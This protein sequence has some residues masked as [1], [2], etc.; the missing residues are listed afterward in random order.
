MTQEEQANKGERIAKFLSRAGI[1][2]RR[3]AERLIQD[4]VVSVN[5]AILDT[6]AFFVTD[7]DIIKVN[8]KTVSGKDKTRLWAYY[9][10]RGCLTSDSDPEERT[11]V[12]DLLPRGLPR[13]MAVGRLDYNSEGLLLLTNDG[14]FKRFLELPNVNIQ[15]RYRAR[16]F[17]R[18]TQE[19]LD[20]L[21]EGV[22]VD[23]M[24]YA[25]VYAE[26][27]KIQGQNAWVTFTLTEGKNRE[28]RKLMTY[29]G[30]DVNR[31]IR[32]DYGACSLGK[33]TDGDVKEIPEEY[34]LKKYSEYF[35]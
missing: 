26:L 29:L 7:S 13:L 22:V 2:S 25:P 32:T 33:M 31:L 35:N 3:E 16:A 14:G 19:R 17:G 20:V 1:A 18:I 6:P 10:P 30:Y 12:F 8:D 4:G 24:H 23:G 28:I 15:R 21:A 9:K 34:L 5:G 27:D 11:T